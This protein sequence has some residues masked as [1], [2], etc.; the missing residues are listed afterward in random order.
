ML[1]AL[2]PDPAAYRAAFP[3]ASPEELLQTVASDWLFRMPSATL[4]RTHADQGGSVFF[5]EFTR[6]AP[7]VHGADVPLVFG[8]GGGPPHPM[9][10]DWASFAHQGTSGW[11]SFDC[12]PG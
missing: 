8:T 5:Y 3:V 9:S 10:A 4:A 2:A 12:R 1:A 11:P 7:A 6:P